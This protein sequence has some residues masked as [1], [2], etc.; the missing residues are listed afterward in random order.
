[1]TT[2]DLYGA[3][4]GLTAAAREVFD[5][6]RYAILGTENPDGSV[7]IVP[8]MYRLDGERIA[9]QTGAGT[10]KARNVA[11]CG[12]ATVLVPDPRANGE[13]WVS[14]AGPA[15]VVHGEEAQAIGRRVRARYLTDLGEDELG[16]VLAR[17][18]DTAIIVTPDRWMAWDTSAYDAMLTAHGLPLEHADRWYR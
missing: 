14:G 13:A 11:R 4:H 8:V 15:E 17:Y 16:S 3:R 7:H 5:H 1:M 12:R 2:I 9:I 10:R 6:A 18:D